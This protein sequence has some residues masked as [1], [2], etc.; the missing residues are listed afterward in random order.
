MT[1]LLSLRARILFGAFLWSMGLFVA[2]GLILPNGVLLF[3]DTHLN[4]DPT[5]E[6]IA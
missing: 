5:A 1:P 2:S 3:C 6:Q 4:M